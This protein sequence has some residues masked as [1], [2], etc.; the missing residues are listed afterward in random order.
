MI[1]YRH[2]VELDNNTYD[3]FFADFSRENHFYYKS[4]L[5]NAKSEAPHT[6][7]NDMECLQKKL[8]EVIDR[9]KISPTMLFLQFDT[10]QN[11]RVSAEE[12][13]SY[14]RSL[15]L[16]VSKRSMQY[17]LNQYTNDQNGLNYTQFV[18]LLLPNPDNKPESPN[19]IIFELALLLLPLQ[20]DLYQILKQKDQ[21]NTGCL[22][23]QEFESAVTQILA[24]FTSED[25]S[26]LFDELDTNQCGNMNYK[27]LWSLVENLLSKSDTLTSEISIVVEHFKDEFF[28]ESDK[29]ERSFRRCDSDADGLIT[30][31]ELAEALYKLG[32]SFKREK[33]DLVFRFLDSS[34]TG[35]ISTLFILR[36]IQKSIW[37]SS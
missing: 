19:N 24:F 3:K 23:R 27:D 22:N 18:N 14:F 9:N 37:E 10:N 26:L 17:L 16:K 32:L 20:Y 6:R 4:F 7:N 12:I 21:Y 2:E 31:G 34:K 15:N 13:T 25:L 30:I 5:E 29:V 28:N 33:L 1:L 8:R 36:T 35:K 11:S